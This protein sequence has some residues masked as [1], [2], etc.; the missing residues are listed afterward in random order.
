MGDLLG[1]GLLTGDLDLP[2]DGVGDG[3]LGELILLFR[4]LFRLSILILGVLK[5]N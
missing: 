2:D 1:G 4:T 3:D 5:R